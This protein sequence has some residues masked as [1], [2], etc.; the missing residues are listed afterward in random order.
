MKVIERELKERLWRKI[1]GIIRVN[2]SLLQ[3]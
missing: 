1:S 2:Y 3:L